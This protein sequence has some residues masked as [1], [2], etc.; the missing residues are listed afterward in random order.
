M[1]DSFANGYALLIAVDENSTAKWVLPDVIKDVTALHQTLTHPSRC[2]YAND[3]VKVLSGKQATKEG[4]LSGLQWLLTCITSDLS[5][6][7]TAFLYYSGHGWCDKEAQPAAYYLVPQNARADDLRRS[8]LPAADLAKEVGA[9]TPRRLFVVLDCCHAGGMDVK[10]LEAESPVSSSIPSRVVMQS[11][12]GAGPQ[13]GEKGLH[14]LGKGA[15]RAVLSSS[16]GTQPSF[17]RKDRTMSVFTYHL[18][19][20]LTGHAQPAQGATEVLVS[21]IMSH[22]SR[23]VPETAMAEN[24]KPQNPDYQVSGNF[25]IALLL[26]GKG[27]ASGQ[28]APTPLED[29]AARLD[30]AISRINAGGGATVGDHLTIQGGGFTGRDH[31]VIDNHSSRGDVIT[32]GDISNSTSVAIGHKAQSTTTGGSVESLEEFFSNLRS[33][34][35]S[36]PS[37]NPVNALVA[38]AG[39]QHEVAKGK[40][41]NDLKVA[42]LIEDFVKLVPTESGSVRNLFAKPALSAIAGNATQF[43]LGK[44]KGL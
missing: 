17:I 14:D 44:L 41:A 4:I 28:Q 8:S 19:E 2:A 7:A 15:G 39:L 20:A 26:G 25:P 10:D 38:L 13:S 36:I 24:N 3:H 27:I 21:D 43:V 23:R 42:T 32:I 6:N 31:I 33:V 29:V 30:R 35:A 1:P 5:G 22:V 9:M 37:G 11:P 40:A 18:I 34:V 16:Q 12:V